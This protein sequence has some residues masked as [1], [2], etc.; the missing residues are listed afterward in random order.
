MDPPSVLDLYRA[1]ESFRGYAPNKGQCKAIESDSRA[2]WILAGPGTGKTEVLVLRVLRLLLVD[3][4]QPESIFFATFTNRAARN[5]E[6]RLTLYLDGIFAHPDFHERK[7]PNASAVWIGTLHSLARDILSQMD[8]GSRDLALLDEKASLFRLLRKFDSGTIMNEELYRALNGHDLPAYLRSNRIH[9][10]ERLKAALDRTIEDHLDRHA[11]QMDEPIQGMSL[12]PTRG[13]QEDFI[14]ILLRYEQALG[15]NADFSRLQRRFLDF[16]RDGASSPFIEGEAQHKLPGVRHVIVDEYQDTNPIQEA[17]YFELSRAA[18]SIAVVGDD[19]QALY[20]FRGASVDAMVR[21]DSRYTERFGDSDI[22]VGL[23]VVSL[24][25]SYRSHPEM[26]NGLNS[27][28]SMVSPASEYQASRIDKPSLKARTL[29]KGLHAPLHVIVGDDEGSIARKIAE[30][31]DGLVRGKLSDPRQVVLLAHSTKVSQK[32]PFGPYQDAL[33]SVGVQTFNPGAKDLHRDPYLRGV[34]GLIGLVIDPHESVLSIQGGRIKDAVGHSQSGNLSPSTFRG[35]A[36]SL[37][38]VHEE[39]ADWVRETSQR[40]DQP[41]DDQSEYPRSWNFLDLFYGVLNQPPFADFLDTQGG[42]HEAIQAWR[43]AW[44]SDMISSFQQNLPDGGTLRQA[45]D[46]EWTRGFYHYRQEK[47]P[48]VI[49]GVSP[50]IVDAFYRDLVR[51]FAEGGFNEVEDEVKS[52]PPGRVPVLTIHQAKGLQFPIV[53][54]VANEPLRGPGPEHHQEELFQPYRVSPASDVTRFS[55]RQRAVQDAIRRF[56]VAISRAQ[57][58]CGI[59]LTRSVFDRLVS[60][61]PQTVEEYAYIPR[62][63]LMSLPIRE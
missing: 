12:W 58:M 23:D 29:L 4:V 27:Y 5:L 14:D 54:V 44:L 35:S 55:Q 45:R 62:K 63:W 30:A 47:S 6:D 60:G 19:D 49:R 33:D 7:R 42:P 56:F 11:L 31:V 37:I 8:E 36:L 9:F 52:L 15:R 3:E 57:V 21:F 53:Y 18:D 13:V 2:L 38:E 16:L 59:A 28:I 32:S 20:R 24:T 48:P 17:I 61:D 40:L 22:G 10:S 46:D 51:L 39:L 43:L 34:L 41:A 26:V 1:F 50:Q 25:D